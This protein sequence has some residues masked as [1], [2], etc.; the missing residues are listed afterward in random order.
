MRHL[1]KIIIS[2]ICFLFAATTLSYASTSAAAFLNINASARIVAMGGLSCSMNDDVSS[3]EV[4]PAGL[5]WIPHTEMLLA[6]NEWFENIRAEYA[7]IGMPI[8]KYV[9]IGAAAYYLYMDDLVRRDNQNIVLGTFGSHS[10]MASLTLSTI[11]SQY[12]SFGI[13]IK[14]V[15]EEIDNNTGNTVCGDAGL[16]IRTRAARLGISVQN[17]GNQLNVY[18]E[19]FPLPTKITGGI[20]FA[21][22][23]YGGFGVDVSKYVENGYDIKTGAEYWLGKCI[24]LRG[25]YTVSNN[26]FQQSHFSM[27][28]GL[29]IGHF[30][31]DYAF[32]PYEYLGNTHRMSLKISF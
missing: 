14:N 28:L 27:G 13:T 5:A 31:L 29:C 20:S 2:I 22:P 10:G 4:N 24:A 26:I 8:G 9:T 19:R 23:Q 25:G 30:T 12:T 7:G 1:S 3:M 11:A 18:E 21:S 6:H 32:V 15:R 16:M 17:I